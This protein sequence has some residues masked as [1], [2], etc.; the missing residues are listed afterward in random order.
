MRLLEHLVLR[1]LRE[2][3]GDEQPLTVQ[4]IGRRAGTIPTHVDPNRQHEVTLALL[5]SLSNQG[6]A[7][8]LPDGRWVQASTVTDTNRN[9]QPEP[10]D[11]GQGGPESS[12]S[13]IG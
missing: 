1:V 7:S 6:L 3:A 11:T 8:D 10:P 9:P 13:G 12:G 5:N 2:V 4:E